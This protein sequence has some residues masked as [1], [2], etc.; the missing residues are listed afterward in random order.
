MINLLFL[1]VSILDIRLSSDTVHQGEIVFLTI[2]TPEQGILSCKYRGDEIPL[3]FVDSEWV[4]LIG[5]SYNT[6]PGKKSLE[7]GFKSASYSEEIFDTSIYVLATKFKKS[8]ISFPASK[9]SAIDTTNQER[10]QKEYKEVQDQINAPSQ[11]FYFLRPDM[12]PCENVIS[13]TY[14]DERWSGDRKLWNH[15]GVDFG[16]WE[17]TPILAP[18][19]GKVVMARDT[20]VFQGTFVLLDHGD[21]LKSMYCHMQK[22]LVDEGSEVKS[23]DTLGFVGSTGFSTGPHL[24]VSVYVRGVPVNP[25][26]WL[27]RKELF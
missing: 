7:I 6:D 25:L 27:E 10:K 23:G 3:S 13:G 17:G 20:F 26:F 8:V 5:T 12:F 22:R 19:P 21:G 9:Q 16:V 24:H 15:A 14:G 4:S 2:K 18:C 1:L 11:G